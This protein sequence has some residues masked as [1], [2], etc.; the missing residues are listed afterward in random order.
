LQTKKDKEKK[1]SNIG[2]TFLTEQILHVQVKLMEFDNRPAT[3]HVE[4][5]AGERMKQ[6]KWSSTVVKARRNDSTSYPILM[7]QEDEIQELERP[8]FKK[9]G[10]K[11]K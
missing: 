4:Y 7:K 1:N 6:Q 8:K 9:S 10:N 3:R 5:E 11:K 2:V